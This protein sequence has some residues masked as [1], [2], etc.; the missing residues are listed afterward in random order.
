LVNGSYYNWSDVL[1]VYDR[2]STQVAA[3]GGNAL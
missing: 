1:K 3:E 2:Q